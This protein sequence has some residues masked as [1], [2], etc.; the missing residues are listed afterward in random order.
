MLTRVW[1]GERS[2]GRACGATNALENLRLRQGGPLATCAPL[3]SG[4]AADS[5]EA[6]GGQCRAAREQ[7]GARCRG[8]VDRRCSAVP[9]TPSPL[10]PSAPPVPLLLALEQPGTRGGWGA[11][12]ARGRRRRMASGGRAPPA[13][14]GRD[15]RWAA[16]TELA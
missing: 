3:R 2:G 5:S 7:G 11:V 4:P 12:H 13:G 16:P 10:L 1:G 6:P 14:Q 8:S 15:K 9:D